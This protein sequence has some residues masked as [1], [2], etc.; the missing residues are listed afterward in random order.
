MGCK[1]SEVLPASDEGRIHI[2]TEKPF[3]ARSC[4][5]S[6]PSVPADVAAAVVDLRLIRPASPTPSVHAD[7]LRSISIEP[8]AGA[9][10]AAG[11]NVPILHSALGSSY[12]AIR[13]F[14]SRR[15]LWQR[16][17]NSRGRG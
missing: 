7:T 17:T 4:D 9:L 10:P 16:Q 14:F 15:L 6:F 3:E 8:K 12:K 13:P 5:E 1:A 11:L 2:S